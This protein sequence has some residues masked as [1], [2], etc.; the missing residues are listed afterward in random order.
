MDSD[1]PAESFGNMPRALRDRLV[2]QSALILDSYERLLGK[3]LIARTSDAA[4]D[5]NH[6]F[7]APFAVLS[8]GTE[9]DPILNYGN[10]I[11][12]ELWE[13]TFEALCALPSRLTAEPLAREARERLMA[14]VTRKGFV[15]GY[16]GTRISST[17]KRF[18]IEN[19]AIFN[20]TQKDGSF[21]GQAATFDRW[22]PLSS[23]NG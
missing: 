10:Q 22:T 12:L 11:A 6:L 8:H 7:A 4:N 17:G 2:S 18:R 23:G 21:A 15:S 19:V 3:Q 16:S 13:T 5:A 14:E 20:L 1:I 9:P